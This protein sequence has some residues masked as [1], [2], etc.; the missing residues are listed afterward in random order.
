MIIFCLFCFGFPLFGY[1]Q[2]YSSSSHDNYYQNLETSA[3][4]A[5]K[6]AYAIVVGISDYP[7]YDN[8]L[9]YCDD[10]ARDVYD[11]LI[12]DYNFKAEN[13][14]L[15]QDTEATKSAI[16]N[17]FKQ[18]ETKIDDN[19]IFF[20]YYSGHGGSDV[21]SD[22]SHSISISSSHPYSND[23]DTMWNIYHENAAYMR[24]HF[25][26]VNLE[27]GYDYVYLGD[28]DL[29]DDWY[30]EDFTGFYTDFWSGW[31]PLLSDNRLYIRF[32]TDYSITDWGFE[33]DMYEAYTYTDTQ[34]LCSYDS[35]PSS[36]DNYFIDTL[37]DSKL[38]ALNCAET[39]VICD[40]CN[41]GGMIDEVQEVGRYIMTACL[42]EESSLED[43]DHQNGCF[44]YYFLNSNDNASDFNGDDLISI[45]ECY[46]YTY[47]NTVSRSTSIGYVHHPMQYDGIS[48]E[49]VLSSAFGSLSLIHTG[50]SLSYSFD[51]CGTGLIQDLDIIVY[52]NTQ[53]L[54]YQTKDLI[55]SAPSITGFG[56]Y[57]GTIQLDGVSGLT[58]YALVARIQGNELIVLQN[59]VSED[60]DN[61]LL[62]DAIEILYGLSHVEIDTDRDGLSDY[63]EFYG[64]TDPLDPDTDNDGLYDGEEVNQYNTDPT[65]PD[66]DGDGS[67][68]GDEVAWGV[69]PLDS[70]FSLM[71]IVLNSIGIVILALVGSYAIISQ[72]IHRRR[73]IGEKQQKGKFGVDKYQPNYNILNIET[74]FKPKPRIPAYQVTARYQPRY[75]PPTPSI[76]VDIKN[77]FDSITYNLHPPNP[78][79]SLKG[80]KAQQIANIAFQF[81]NRGDFQSAIDYMIKALDS[82]VPEPTNSHIRK[83]LLDLLNS[84]AA[85]SGSRPDLFLQSGEK[86]QSCGHVNNKSN[87][88][89]INCGRAL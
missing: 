15:L 74:I 68:D 32:I 31:I 65:N 76:Q 2:Q 45:E 40:S 73:V 9:S 70:R 62:D 89:C 22:G 21:V 42:A 1:F 34:Y 87:K 63:E 28:T 82:G 49:A 88:F 14:I 66:T 79:Y 41:S 23:L 78:P 10:D 25:N 24:V 44:T 72:I 36:P 37:L 50:N 86:C 47:S 81:F 26:E 48:G 51:L 20:F 43:A 53:S 84:L 59:T 27:S 33:I 58:G 67:L 52:N 69:D 17:A 16:S 39:Y 64:P 61:D 77:L 29:Y 75:S 12:D 38:D 83:I 11:M 19:D 60:T 30:Y 57:S 35:L 5:A 7:G 4:L 3:P 8:D 46:N 56:S 85:T 80:L 55:L 6:E 54:V 18:I 13:I 71:T